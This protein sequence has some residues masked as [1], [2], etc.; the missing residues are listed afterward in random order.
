MQTTWD[1]LE[2]NRAAIFRAIVF[3]RR[4]FL[5]VIHAFL[6]PQEGKNLCDALSIYI[7]GI[8]NTQTLLVLT[9][10]NKIRI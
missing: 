7:V 9:I 10:G 5:A 1:L 8:N 3:I 4:K 6:L 2:Q